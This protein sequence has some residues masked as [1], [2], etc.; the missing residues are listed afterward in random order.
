MES[1]CRQGEPQGAA[2][3]LLTGLPGGA[4]KG[5]G[6]QCSQSSPSWMVVTFCTCLTWKWAAP[7]PVISSPQAGASSNHRCSMIVPRSEQQHLHSI[8][9]AAERPSIDLLCK[10]CSHSRGLQSRYEFTASFQAGLPKMSAKCHSSISYISSKC[11]PQSSVSCF[12]LT[13]WKQPSFVQDRDVTSG[14]IE[15]GHM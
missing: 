9:A 11:S 13:D 6:A 10:H 12:H 2:V 14:H 4:G 15:M 8:T 5:T 7:L 1:T 3:H